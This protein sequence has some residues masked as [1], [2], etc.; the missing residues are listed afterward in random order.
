MKKV[1]LGIVILL[2]IVVISFLIS[3][4]IKKLQTQKLIAEKIYSLPSF[5]FLTLS[6]E[7]YRSTIIQK[8][9]VLIVHFHPECEHC[10]YEISEILKSK[11]PI[12]FSTIILVSS[13]HPESIRNFLS[14]FNL[15]NYSSVIPLLDTSYEF[16]EFFGSG[17]VP[18]TYIY[19]RNLNLVKVLQG[20]VKTE[21]IL[22][23]LQQSE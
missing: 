10:Q 19:N 13:A 3:G 5:T 6:N 2:V 8:G 12:Y 4:I 17:I 1:L 14:N 11:I 20:E 7:S 15:K 23:Y 9:P 21:T 16:E 22:K 18:S